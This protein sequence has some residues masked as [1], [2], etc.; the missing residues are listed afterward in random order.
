MPW[1]RRSVEELRAKFIEEVKAGIESKAALCR[2]YGISRPTGDKWLRRAEASA[3]LS[4]LPRAPHHQAGRTAVKKE[5]MILDLRAK[6]PGIGARKIKRILENRGETMPSV[7]TVNNILK[8]HGCI[9]LEASLAN[10]APVRFEM[11]APNDMWQAD[12]KGNFG[13]ANGQRCHILNVLDDCSRF[14]LCS[15]ANASEKLEPTKRSFE[16]VFREYGLPKRLLCD[17]GNPW[18]TSQSAGYT[19]FEVW[20]MEL[21]IRPVHGRIRHPQTQGKQERFNGSLQRELLNHTTFRDY[22]DAQEQLDAY[23][24]YY[25]NERPHEA[26]ELRTPAQ[27][28]TPSPRQMPRIILP[29]EY[30]RGELRKVKSSGFVTYRSQGYFLSEAFADKEVCLIPDPETDGRIHVLFRQFRIACIDL[31]ERCVISRRILN[32]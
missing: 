3:S 6:H 18:G 20:L 24:W 5:A 26:L 8:R 7:T 13:M 28:Y 25:N 29:W 14:E 10:H 2:K 22:A 21:G 11:K 32:V 4:D 17:N 12:F 1:E 15:D 31:R 27:L 9:T 23:R 16:Q 19:K 30:E